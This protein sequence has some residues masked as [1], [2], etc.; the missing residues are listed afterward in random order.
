MS[1]VIEF[2]P[3]VLALVYTIAFTFFVAWD[4]QHDNDLRHLDDGLGTE[5]IFAKAARG[6]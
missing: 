2:Y 3:Y 1:I 5:E 4:I 6:D